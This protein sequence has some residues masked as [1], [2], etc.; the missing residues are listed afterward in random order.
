MVLEL[1]LLIHQSSIFFFGRLLVSFLAKEH[2]VLVGELVIFQASWG[3]E[4]C[5]GLVA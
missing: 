1:L 4:Q 2:L 3:F 5:I